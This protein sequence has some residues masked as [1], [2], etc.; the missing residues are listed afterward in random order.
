MSLSKGNS[1][2]SSEFIK[3]SLINF[4][5]MFGQSMVNILIPKYANSLGA[6]PT[7]VGIVTSVFALSALLIKPFSGPAIDS[8]NKKYIL[9]GSGILI[10]LA[11]LIYS[12]ADSINLLILARL[13]HGFGLGFTVLACLTIVSDIVPEKDLTTGIAVFS[14]A[15]AVSSAFGP[16]TGL[17]LL[18]ALGFSTTFLIGMTIMI[19][20]SITALTLK[21]TN[22]SSIKYRID[23]KN[24]YAKEA[25][26]P[27]TIMMLLSAVYVNVT[28]FI[29]LFSES[30][31]VMN[32]GLF[33][34][35]NALA[36]VFSRPI[37]A[38]LSDRFGIEKMLPLSIVVF[39]LSMIFISYS[40]SQSMF[41]FAAILNAFGYGAAQP[42]IQSLCM[43]SVPK[44][45]R[46]SASATSYYG[47][48]I[49]YLAG[50]VISGKIIESFGYQMMFRFTPVLLGIALF[51]F[52]SYRTKIIAIDR[53]Q[54]VEK[55]LNS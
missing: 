26:I 13:V 31:G 20:S 15:A 23:F 40:N 37:I 10:S 49:G 17:L 55:V 38:R 33:F 12:V 11:F 27:A 28:A 6:T 18:K 19:L 14:V 41:L 3:I 43:K 52:F 53:Y 9:F 21:T 24:L 44:N 2:L 32:I 22:K 51:V 35:V 4:A 1:F 34:T 42:L 29:V 54:E 39:G 30:V 8:F 46:G 5:M 25:L 16:Q 45:R 47:T 48:D 50:P 7:I 36:L